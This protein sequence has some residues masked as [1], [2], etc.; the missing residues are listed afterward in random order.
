MFDEGV[1][2]LLHSAFI[3]KNNQP[4]LTQSKIT[5]SAHIT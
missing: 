4:K 3:V 5:L 2:G 1:L